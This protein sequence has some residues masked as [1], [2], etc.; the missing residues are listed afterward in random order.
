[1]PWKRLNKKE[2]RLQLKPWLTQGI[3]KSIK[4]R[5]KLLRKCIE[6]RVRV[7]VRVNLF[8]EKNQHTQITTNNLQ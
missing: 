3:L 5:D 6:S 1:M 7:R 8:W 2:L 4:R